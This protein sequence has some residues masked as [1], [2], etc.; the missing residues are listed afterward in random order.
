MT[1]KGGDSPMQRLYLHNSQSLTCRNPAGARRPGEAVLICFYADPA[2]L[3]DNVTLRL[4]LGEG[5]V[6][7]PMQID[8]TDERGWRRYAATIRM[9]TAP[10]WLWYYFLID[11]GPNR[12]YYGN[13]P[14][15]L[16]G[17]GEVYD[18]EPPSFQITVYDAAYDIPR[19]LREGVLYHIFV[20]RFFD[21]EGR[22]RLRALPEDYIAR[23]AWGG[24]PFYHADP[25]DKTD[26]MDHFGGNLQGIRQKLPYLAGLGV[27][28]LYL[29]P[30]FEARSN[31]KYNTADYLTVDPAFGTAEDFT[32]LCRDARQRGIRVILDGVFAHTGAVS[33]YFNRDGRY[34]DL[35][36]Y[37][38]PDSPYYPWYRFRSFPDDYES[39]WGFPSLPQTD[40]NNPAFQAFIY[41]EGGVVP[42]WM[43]RGASGWRIDVVDELPS[44][45][46]EGLYKAVKAADPEGVVIGEVWEDASR[47]ESYG[48]LRRY[49]QGRQLDG[50]MN[51]P[52]RGAILDFL[53][54]R[55]DAGALHRRICSLKENYPEPFLAGCMNLLSSHDVPRAKTL[56]GGADDAY[57]APRAIQERVRLSAAQDRLATRRLML[58]SLITYSLPGVP[59]L[60]YGDE[61]GMIGM[62]DPFNRGVYP[63]DN[64]DEALIDWF[65]ALG[66][67]RRDVK[68]LTEGA[69]VSLPVEADL[70]A[71]LR[72]GPGEAWA[73]TVINRSNRRRAVRIPLQL[74]GGAAVALGEARLTLKRNQLAVSLPPVSGAVILPAND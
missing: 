37:Q 54:G 9:P 21:G 11:R 30:I 36:A 51:Y 25:A 63:W 28:I 22:A 13:N 2:A 56:L 73:L 24:T 40:A 4:W 15:N 14:D 55:Q 69:L 57:G 68:A 29:S 10:G 3:P 60:Y 34:P 50:V 1:Q 70:Y 44:A 26:P 12:S 27:T 41:G 17:E 31:H 65:R 5:E 39:W 45:F 7:V 47:K 64:P 16:G 61:A 62:G 42:F 72:Q 38:S 35:G 18:H 66:A 8:G 23:E 20:D 32:A 59:S 49:A 71:L 58:A 48:T 43:G 52:L 33:R 19:W 6:R 74:A 53:R 46:V 67:L